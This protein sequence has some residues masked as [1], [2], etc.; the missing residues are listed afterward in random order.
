MTE[1]EQPAKRPTHSILGPLAGLCGTLILLAWIGLA[2]RAEPKTAA[3]MYQPAATPEVVVKT[4]VV[5]VE[6]RVDPEPPPPPKVEPDRAAIAR[7]EEALDAAT[8]E[9][10]ESEARLADAGLA[11]RKAALDSACPRCCNE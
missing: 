9:R 1:T 2:G 3:P 4:A 11:L 8:R 6:P 10:I 5:A 7:A